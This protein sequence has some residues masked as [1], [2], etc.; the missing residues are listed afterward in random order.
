MFKCLLRL[1]GT[2][3]FDIVAQTQN[4][5]HT[6]VQLLK[7]T[8]LTLRHT[9][10]YTRTQRRT[11][12]CSCKE[13]GMTSLHPSS[14]LYVVL[15]SLFPLYDL[16][17]CLYFPK[18]LPV[19]T[20]GVN[21]EPPY[22][23]THTNS[24]AHTHTHFKTLSPPPLLIILHPLLP[25]SS[26]V[27][28]CSSCPLLS[29]LGLLILIC[30]PLCA[31]YSWIILVVVYCI[32][33]SGPTLNSFLLKSPRKYQ[34][35]FLWWWIWPPFTH[36]YPSKAFCTCVFYYLFVPHLFLLLLFSAV[37]LSSFVEVPL[38]TSAAIAE[39]SVWPRFVCLHCWFQEVLL[40][41]YSRNHISF[42]PPWNILRA[43]CLLQEKSVWHRQFKDSR[44][45]RQTPFQLYF[46]FF[47][48]LVLGLW[49]FWVWLWQLCYFI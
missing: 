2:W 23:Q 37:S 45:A 21:N 14:S 15:P 28:L 13:F 42:F 8:L 22:T 27:P 6:D 17:A 10:T 1:S 46:G 29:F 12:G 3:H 47:R 48:L 4:A 20:H 41:C 39:F 38:T 7:Q 5:R 49:M 24:R 40:F 26:A 44:K 36:F 33:K 18:E 32:M 35:F 19:G 43:S 25:T 30:S 34:I 11:Q 16:S 9:H 31:L